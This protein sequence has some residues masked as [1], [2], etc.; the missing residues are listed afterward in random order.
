MVLT[1]QE[2]TWAEMRTD[3]AA[4]Q[5]SPYVCVLTM[6]GISGLLSEKQSGRNSAPLALVP[7]AHSQQ[8][9]TALHWLSP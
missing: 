8:L 4:T 6:S 3:T 1:T 5:L 2:P 7:A 9:L